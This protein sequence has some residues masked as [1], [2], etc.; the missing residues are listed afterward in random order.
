MTAPPAPLQGSDHS[1]QSLWVPHGDGEEQL[2]PARFQPLRPVT[3]PESFSRPDHQEAFTLLC[4]AAR[5]VGSRSQGS[6]E[7]SRQAFEYRPGFVE[8][9]LSVLKEKEKTSVVG[10]RM[11][12][13]TV[14]N[15]S[16]I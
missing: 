13:F 6:W 2:L 14:T 5:A 12:L 9:L 1:S 16:D 15:F 7:P 11:V 10:F 3:C 4:R 8:L